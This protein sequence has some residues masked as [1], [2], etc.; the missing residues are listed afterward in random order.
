MSKCG[1]VVEQQRWQQQHQFDLVVLRF[2]VFLCWICE[3]TTPVT[4]VVFIQFSIILWKI[5]SK[6]ADSNE[7]SL[8]NVHVNER[9]NEWTSEIQCIAICSSHSTVL[10]PQALSHTHFQLVSCPFRLRLVIL[11]FRFVGKQLLVF[12]VTCVFPSRFFRFGF[13]SFDSGSEPVF[14]MKIY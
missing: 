2:V 4:P 7:S 14:R 9:T 3:R 6:S 8:W 13:C 5:Q 11:S 10:L 12:F 1:D